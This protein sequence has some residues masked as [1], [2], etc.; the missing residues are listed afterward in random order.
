MNSKVEKKPPENKKIFI[1]GLPK[2]LT[3]EEFKAYFEK[4]GEILDIAIICDKKTKEPRG[5][6]F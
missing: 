3:L 2:E 1:G 4:F 6:L 5:T